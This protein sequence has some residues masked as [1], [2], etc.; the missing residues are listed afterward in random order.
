MEKQIAKEFALESVVKTAVQIPGV[1]VNRNKFLAEV[2]S[3]VPEKINEIVELGPIAAGITREDLQRLSKKH[4]L[5]RTSES[6]A[7]SFVA[8]LPGGFAMAATI[9]AD[10]LQFFG[11]AVR[12]AQELSYLYGAC[13]LWD[14]KEINEERVNNQLLLYIG[15]MFGVS[16]AVSGVRVLTTQLSK[17]VL[18]KL[19]QKALTETFW[20]PIVKQIGKALGIRVTKNAVAQGVSKVVPIVGGVVSGTLNFASMYP[21][22]NRLQE[23]L[24]KA[25]FAYSEEEFLQ[26]VEIVEQTDENG[27]I[28]AD[29]TFLE[30][31]TRDVKDG[32]GKLAE[33]VKNSSEKLSQGVKSG[34]KTIGGSIS[35]AFSRIKANTENKKKPDMDKTLETIE[36]LAQ[37]RDAGIL[38]EE[39]FDHKKKE[40]LGIDMN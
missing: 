17:T 25:C 2:F 26:D 27:K 5:K 24:D 10:V 39:E 18:K 28:E 9:P 38:T 30:K 4:I 40:L 3:F 13:D 6:S 22:A 34:M 33:G 15:T 31:I 7:A 29:L 8:G 16:G 14:G 35:G 23:T 11:M 12:L 1:K 36:K 21:M 37:L 32:S 20:Y 19:P